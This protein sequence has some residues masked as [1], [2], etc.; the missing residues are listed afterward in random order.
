MLQCA[1]KI[2]HNLDERQ[3]N[4]LANVCHVKI[5]IAKQFDVEDNDLFNSF[6]KASGSSQ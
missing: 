1:Y 5:K 2:V 6:V 3:M 4:K